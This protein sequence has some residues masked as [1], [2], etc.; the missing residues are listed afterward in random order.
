MKLQLCLAESV[1][2]D[3]SMDDGRDAPDPPGIQRE[4]TRH[5]ASGHGSVLRTPTTTEQSHSLFHCCLLIWFSVPSVL[6]ASL[7]SAGLRTTDPQPLQILTIST[8]RSDSLVH[9]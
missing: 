2:K 3:V 4:S 5:E 7:F 6:S 1:M 8:R 9:K